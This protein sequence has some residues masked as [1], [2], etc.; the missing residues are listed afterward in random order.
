MERLLKLGK[1]E[2]IKEGPPSKQRCRLVV[3]QTQLH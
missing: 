3:V 1:I 2:Q